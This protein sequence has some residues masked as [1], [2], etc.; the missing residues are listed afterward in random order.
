MTYSAFNRR[1]F[2]PAGK[3][4]PMKNDLSES[5]QTQGL[6]SA[7]FK[8]ILMAAVW[9][10]LIVGGS[11]AP[12]NVKESSKFLT[13]AQGAAPLSGVAGPVDRRMFYKVAGVIAST[14]VISFLCWFVAYPT[15]LRHGN[16]WPVTLYGRCTAVAWCASWLIALWIFKDDLPIPPRDTFLRANGLRYLF[17][18]IA[19]FFAIV[20]ILVW[21][22]QKQTNR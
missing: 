11:R 22:S 7:G 4:T 5:T 18:I 19:F 6:F 10:T 8:Q 20:S 13:V 16:A 15:I 21:R 1:I 3:I 14:L 12:G 9:T 17:V 2:N